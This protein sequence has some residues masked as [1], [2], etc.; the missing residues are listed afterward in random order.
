MTPDT[1]DKPKQETFTMA[2]QGWKNY[3]T[4]NVSL[5]VNNEEP[6]YRAMCEQ[7]PFTTA[8]AETFCREAFPDGT[9]DM[10]TDEDWSK[11]SKAAARER[12]NLV[13]WQEIADAFNE[14]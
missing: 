12:M 1:D 10:Q 6:L 7:R 11:L 8:T 14:E 9:P 2:Y 4:W 13:D 3:E 5:Y